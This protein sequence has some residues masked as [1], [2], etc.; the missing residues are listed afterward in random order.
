MTASKGADLAASSERD[1]VA[2]VMEN[3]RNWSVWLSPDA[4]VVELAALMAGLRSGG[5][6]VAAEH[7]GAGA[8]ALVP[9][10]PTPAP[11]G[12]WIISILGEQ[13]RP[14]PSLVS[15]L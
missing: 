4:T 6:E 7:M 1:N 3:G 8:F 11:S 14:L 2:T 5:V 13:P 12:E 10:K 9:L 15:R